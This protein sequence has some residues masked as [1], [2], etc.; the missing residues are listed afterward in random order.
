MDHRIS[1]QEL[2]FNCWNSYI[3]RIQR[4]KQNIHM[5]KKLYPLKFIPVASRRPWGG[6][7]LVNQLGKKFVESDEDGNETVLGSDVLIGE[8][9]ELADMGIEDSVV[10]E[11]WLAGNTIGELMETYLERLVGENVYNSYGRQFPLLIKFL[12]INDKLSVQV[13]PDDEVAA[14]RY[15]SLGKAEIW[16]VMDAKPGAKMYC[17]FKRDVS[18]Q[19][20]Y[21]RCKNGTV[22]EILNVI[23]P[24]KGDVIYITPGTVHA[25][26]GGLLIAEIQESSDMTFRLYDWGREFNPATARKTHLEEAI[27]VIDY[28]AFDFG[29]YRKG[30]LWGEEASTEPCHKGE[31]EEHTHD[32]GKVVETL[33]ECPQFN[34]SKLTL[35][36]PLHIYTEKF[37][38]FIIYICIDGA[39]SIQVPGVNEKGEECMQNY[40]FAKG[41]TILVPAEMPDFYLVP[42]DKSTVLLEAVTRPVEDMD[43][44]IDP[45]TEAFL[46]DEDY[47]GL[48]DEM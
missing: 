32:E 18:A 4:N 3:C 31:C 42:K 47:E 48:E 41:E 29:L 22:D 23:E 9:W 7:A 21:D 28:R 11:G 33:V 17:G 16:Y 45:E 6:N 39:A 19:E 5:E 26:D 34:V 25:A 2:Y 1:F 40:D 12:D 46:E 8:S 35:T 15:D 43:E 38:S 10:A 13:H 27:D 37:E 24:K 20:F 44:Y 36:D 30:P 14:E